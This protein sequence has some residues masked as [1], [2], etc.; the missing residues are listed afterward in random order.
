MSPLALPAILASTAL[1][2]SCTSSRTSEAAEP[3]TGAEAP[4]E[5]TAAS[6]PRA[7]DGQGTFGD[8]V[9]VA[10]SLASS[11]LAGSSAGCLLGREG[12]DFVLA[13]D[14]MPSLERM[15][16]PPTD[17]GA[18]FERG[19][20]PV[21]VL[22]AW[23]MA[24]TPQAT[25]ILAAFTATPP[26]TLQTPPVLLVLDRERAFVRAAAAGSESDAAELTIP[27]AVA[28]AKQ[29]AGASPLYVTATAGF[30][31][32][33][34]A[35]VLAQLDASPQANV[36]LAVLL[37]TD[38]ALPSGGPQISTE[39]CP[40]G[41]PEVDES[42]PLGDLS[43]DAVMPALA[44]LKSDIAPC[45]TSLRV[46]STRVVVALRVGPSGSVQSACLMDA[47][48]L[49]PRTASCVLLVA[50]A[51]QTAVPNPHGVVDLHLPLTLQNEPL[52]AQRALCA[53]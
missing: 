40:T 14:L 51:L 39:V 13:A 10:R 5:A 49:D 52:P 22:T 33:D 19:A 34:L 9:R 46:A 47:G 3:T 4:S 11:D 38:T 42:T 2:A 16:D 29:L 6:S 37:P 41:L 27:A 24:G 28:R 31:L 44:E 30:A 15:P 35:S 50:G 7:L 20:E 36:A 48:A 32:A 23:G 53:Q 21:A 45:L 18:R 17:L 25:T 1:L 12:D 26:S 43:R 8:L